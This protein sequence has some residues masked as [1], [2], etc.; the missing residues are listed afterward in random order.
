MTKPKQNES[1]ATLQK[2]LSERILILDGAMGTMIQG[3]KLEEADYRGERFA[4]YDRDIK[5]N[6]DLLSITQ[7]Q[8]IEEIHTQ[9]LA[10]GADI[11]ETNTFN[12]T[13]ISQADYGMQDLTR[14]LNMESAKVARRAVDKFVAANP[15]RKCFVAG[16]LGPTSRTASMSP[17]VNNPGYRAV[18]FDD[19]VTAYM[20]QTEALLD[21]GV[22]ALLL[23]T[24][25]D[26]LN[27][28]AALFA[29]E[30]VFENRGVRFPVMISVTITDA[31]G[32]TLSGQT[33]E[34]FWN[35]VSHSKPLSVGIN[36]ALGPKEMRPYME[37]LSRIANCYTSCYPNAG[38]PNAF[39]GYDETPAQMAAVLEDFAKEG[40]LNLVGGCCG[41]K[42]EH[43]AAIAEAVKK[44]PA[45]V[46]PEIEPA[47]RLSGLE[48]LTIR[49]G[50]PFMLVGERTNVTG[51][52]K[53]SKLIIAEDYEAALAVARQQVESG[54]NILDIN[55]DEGMLDSE[56]VMVKFLHLVVSEPEISK[57]PIMID[58]SKWSVLEAGL[59]C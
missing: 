1:Y 49:D 30:N 15:D 28:K 46:I 21:G 43:I 2:L 25:F 36:C 47:T 59:K 44:F 14:D 12:S 35:S 27:A 34:A 51:S 24:I 41:S 38:L 58:S 45:R 57:V 17:D 7:P 29:V 52:P 54:A 5:G 6:N 33:L 32:R 48:P 9:Y 8:I 18:T 10:A 13:S 16:A 20:E 19:L 23:E 4:N 53:F 42:P 3:Y 55:V 40:W 56:A 26:T 37:E 11:I 31:S 39:G 22:D 50:S